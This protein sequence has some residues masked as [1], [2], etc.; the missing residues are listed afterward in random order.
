MNYLEK[1]ADSHQR[2]SDDIDDEVSELLKG[3]CNPLT[4]NN[5]MDAISNGEALYQNGGIER[6]VELMEE[7]DLLQL[8]R[9][10]YDRVISYWEK[11]AEE[12][13]VD[14]YN[15]SWGDER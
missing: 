8:G 3:E 6:M 12:I 10:V 5:I 4:P 2:I 13:A 11:Q 15:S 1:L 9:M 7:R 14:R